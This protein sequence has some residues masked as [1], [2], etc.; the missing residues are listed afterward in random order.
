MRMLSL[1]DEFMPACESTTVP[2]APG[3]WF[4][5][6]GSTLLVHAVTGG[7]TVELPHGAV[8]LPAEQPPRCA[9][10]FWGS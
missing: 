1:P 2:E 8:W 4:A 9:A 5:F 6:T 10:C 7:G 3:W